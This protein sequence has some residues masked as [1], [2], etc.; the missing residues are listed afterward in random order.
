[1]SVDTAEDRRS[2][3]RHRRDPAGGRAAGALGSPHA[4]LHLE[5]ARRAVRRLGV[6]Q[7]REP[8]ES[9]RVQ[10]SR[11]DERGPPARRRRARRGVITHSSG[12]HG[13]AVA[14]AGR[15]LR[16][17]GDGRDAADGPGREARGDRG[18][19]CADR[20]VRADDRLARGDGGRRDRAA[21]VHA[22]SSVQRLERD[23]RPGNGGAGSCSSR[24][25]SST[26]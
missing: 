10:V 21:W 19:W 6:S 11:C 15:L 2:R 17:A 18:L 9:R 4:R 5:V 12:N 7:V 16:R 1:M 23:R 20:A 24:P 22:G 25:A 26:W 14:L 8:S 13:Q 3:H